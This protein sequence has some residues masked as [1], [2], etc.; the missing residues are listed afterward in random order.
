MAADTISTPWTEDQ[1]AS[2]NAFQRSGLF[3]PF[4]C[5]AEH[6]RRQTLVAEADGWHCPDPDCSYTQPWA[7]SFMA[8]PEI[9][10][11]MQRS[12]TWQA[13]VHAPD[14]DEELRRYKGLLRE[15][16]DEIA[17]L[18]GEVGT[19]KQQLHAMKIVLSRVTVAQKVGLSPSVE[20]TAGDCDAMWVLGD[21]GGRT[22][23]DVDTGGV[24]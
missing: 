16:E 12:W 21:T 8:D 2:L 11:T 17:E 23:E 4:T 20:Q 18:R 3:H 10:R 24:L 14:K 15:A 5:N 9:L 13:P 6:D 22:V 19:L 1:V 7:H